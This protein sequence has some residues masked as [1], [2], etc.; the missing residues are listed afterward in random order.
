MEVVLKVKDEV[1][2]KLEEHK[3]DYFSGESLAGDLH[4]SRNS[5]WKAV[6]SLKKDGYNIESVTNKGYC[7]S[8][9]NDILSPQ[10]ISKYLSS[11]I[12][13]NIEVHKT[14]TSTNSLLKEAATNKAPE[15][16]VI[17]AESQTMGRGRLGRTFH[18]PA[19]S[20]IYFSIL[21]RPEISAEDS[22]YLT[23]AAAVAIAKAI[24]DVKE[25]T[26]DI[27][28]VNDIYIDNKKVCGI[29]TE[30]SF[31]IEN[32]E[33]DYAIVGIGINIT[34]PDDDFPDDIKNKAGAIFSDK[35]DTTGIKSILVAKVLNY[36]FDY[37]K[38]LDSKTFFDEYKKRSFLLGKNITILDPNGEIPASAIDLDDR[39]HLIVRLA[40]GTIK[41]LS[42]GEVS[43]IMN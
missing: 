28:W 31:N 8:S 39:C 24:E 36:F 35:E 13:L 2:K 10:S 38:T 26:A 17:V 23:T 32:N 15:G 5:I 11:D 33:L 43:V 19:G 34:T 27:K 21:L 37:Y 29:L 20:G 12:K 4:V 9:T 22:L 41:E 14:V 6:N 16:T 18:S 7:L 25:C 42:S 40:D 1:L 30:G 3:G